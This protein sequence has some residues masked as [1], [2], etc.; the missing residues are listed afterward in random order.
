MAAIKALNI[1]HPCD[2]LALLWELRRDAQKPRN[3]GG[4]DIAAGHAKKT[5]QRPTAKAGSQAIDHGEH[6]I[7]ALTASASGELSN[8][9]SNNNV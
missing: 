5:Q 1:S 8:Q 9:R 7:H 4:A 6:L 2:A 3:G